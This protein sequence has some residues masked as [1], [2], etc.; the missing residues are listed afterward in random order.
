MLIPQASGYV[1][2]SLIQGGRL[3]ARE[4]SKAL[5]L[6]QIDDR[7]ISYLSE[8]TRTPYLIFQ[9]DELLLDAYEKRPYR[10]IAIKLK[11]NITSKINNKV[12]E[13]DLQTALAGAS[14]IILG[15]GSSHE[16][17]HVLLPNDLFK[18]C[19]NL[20]CM[21]ILSRCSFSFVLYHPLSPDATH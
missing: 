3:L 5:L 17:P 18:Q 1:T 15:S 10:W 7:I 21:L 12:Q 14:S 9:D 4:I 6:P 8:K 13:A 19:N 11:N 16:S 20:I 2:G